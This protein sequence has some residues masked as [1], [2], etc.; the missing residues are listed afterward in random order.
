MMKIFMSAYLIMLSYCSL[1]QNFGSKLLS[2][3]ALDSCIGKSP[4]ELQ[5]TIR[6]EKIKYD[7][8]R[9]AVYPFVDYVVEPNIRHYVFRR[10]TVK[11]V[12]LT[13]N[14]KNF[15]TAISLYLDADGDAVYSALAE[16]YGPAD[17][18]GSINAAEAFGTGS[19]VVN[20]LWKV[21]DKCL[22]FQKNESNKS[23]KIVIDNLKF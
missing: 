9:K 4:D 6:I 18:K 20:Y 22:Q 2:L 8:I 21:R 14:E 10:F 11:T 17:F 13:V 16:I 7:S 3:N 19:S 15:V 23:H 12:Y 5:G 1:G